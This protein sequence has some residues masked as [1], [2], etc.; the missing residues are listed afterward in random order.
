MKTVLMMQDEKMAERGIEN[1]ISRLSNVREPWGANCA[2]SEN[3][4][5]HKEIVVIDDES[6]TRELFSNV[7]FKAG[8]NTVSFGDNASAIRY[9]RDI[10]HVIDLLVLD[11]NMPNVNGRF[12]CEMTR[13]KHPLAKI[14][15]ASNYA[16]DVQRYLIF[17]ADAYF[18]KSEGIK[19]LR[20]KVSNVLSTRTKE[21]SGKEEEDD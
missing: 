4:K 6:K 10:S 1:G 15:I 3:S 9:L 21:E 17:D 2:S 18:D 7:F 13:A 12:F 11:L 19:A 8:Y 5:R 20:K 14:L 16:T